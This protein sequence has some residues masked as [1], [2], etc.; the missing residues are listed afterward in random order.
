MI[1]LKQVRL[2]IVN[3]SPMNEKI[4]GVIA[5]IVVIA[6]G[7][8]LFSKAPVSAPQAS[9][10]TPTPIGT[11]NPVT[12]TPPTATPA[13][14]K[15]TIAY[16]DQGF[17]PKSVTMLLGTTVTFVNQ[18][19]QRMWV[20]SA[21][22]PTHTAYN[23]TSLSQHCP[24][25]NN[26]AFDQCVAVGSGGSFSFVFNKEGTWKYHD[27]VSPSAFGSVTVTAAASASVNVPI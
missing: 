1:R 12:S 22:H 21:M 3:H 6:G 20:A 9:V 15:V 5:V 27:H 7:W 11:Q 17:S 4:I 16:T 2:F 14:S 13:P 25:R 26:S 8:Y 10:P 24:D 23:G 18:S 19:S